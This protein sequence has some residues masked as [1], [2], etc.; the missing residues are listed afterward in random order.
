MS[1]HSDCI[2]EGVRRGSK[3]LRHC[4]GLAPLTV[5]LRNQRLKYGRRVARGLHQIRVRNVHFRRRIECQADHAVR[6]VRM[7][8]AKPAVRNGPTTSVVIGVNEVFNALA[9]RVVLVLQRYVVTVAQRAVRRHHVHIA[10]GILNIAHELVA[11]FNEQHARLGQN[12]HIG[13]HAHRFNN[14]IKTVGM[15]VPLRLHGEPVLLFGC[16]E[17]GLV[18]IALQDFCAFGPHFVRLFHVGG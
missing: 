16:N 14:E 7:G 15:R 6:V 13:I 18:A 11:F 3:G 4:D 9:Q 5:N 12:L 17:C 10:A 1:K 2:R 8:F